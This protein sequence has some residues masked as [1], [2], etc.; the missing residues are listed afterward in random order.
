[1]HVV[2]L[3]GGIGSGKSTVAARLEEHGAVVVDVD[4]VAHGT[5]RKGQPAYDALLAHFGEGIVGEDGEIDRR[6]LGAA[7]FGDPAQLKALTDVVW[8]ATYRA[9]R[10]A[11]RA[12]RDKGAAVVVLE[13]AVLIEANWMDTSDE[14]WVITT[15]PENAIQRVMTRNG[16]TRQQ[17]QER[18]ASQLSNE[19]RLVYADVHIA[20]DGSLE[21]L[22]QRVDEEWA[23]LQERL[24]ASAT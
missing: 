15:S 14:I 24:A 19:E 7:V 11:I 2:G 1:M 8:P 21:E 3:T 12:E 10:D 22:Y 6:L 20:N 18:I 17:A 13:A 4:R 9:S 16:L 5:Y 23:A